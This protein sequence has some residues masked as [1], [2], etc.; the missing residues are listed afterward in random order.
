M[1]CRQSVGVPLTIPTALPQHFPDVY[2][3]LSSE[4]GPRTDW[5]PF[6]ITESQQDG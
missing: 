4:Y 3:C 5:V 2:S 6:H 1:Q